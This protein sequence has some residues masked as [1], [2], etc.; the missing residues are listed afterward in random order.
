MNTITT[1]IHDKQVPL[2]VNL[3]IL[4]VIG[5]GGGGS[6]A[7]N[8]MIELGLEGVD[9][10]AAN[11]DSQA[12]NHSL[13]N[14]KIHLGRR[15]H[16]GLGA[17]GDPKIGK[18]ATEESYQE[19]NSVLKD[20]DMVF[21]TAGMGGGTGTGAIPIVAKIAHT[22]DIVTIAIVTM[23][24][25]FEGGTR[26]RNAR[27]GVNQLRPFTNT[28]I[29]VPN[30]KLLQIARRDLPLELAFRLADDVL[31]QAIQGITELITQPGL[32]NI[33][34]ANIRQ[35]MQNGGGSIFSIGYG[36]GENKAQLA[37]EQALNHP[38]LESIPIENANGLIANFSGGPDLT[39][40]EVSDALTKLRETTNHGAEIIPGI[41]SDE[42]M[43]GRVQVILIITGLGATPIDV[44]YS[45][46]RN[47]VVL[48][49]PVED[50]TLLSNIPIKLSKMEMVSTP[51][52]LDLPAFM[53][54]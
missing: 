23:P 54:R 26:L 7:I 1:S 49:C 20:T 9:Y 15:L 30:D 51:A 5:L 18:A 36:Q 19:L 25:S 21:L 42:R 22:L 28:L 2:T 29:V 31:R 37:I 47:T 40:F 6:N 24:F 14:T 52:D 13:A 8:R 48:P 3:P 32:I 46:Y 10:I 45:N 16:R 50:S 41:V 44:N 11:T 53:R 17:G 38:I 43:Q 34:F 35:L 27:E 12:L 4:K 33:D 39:L